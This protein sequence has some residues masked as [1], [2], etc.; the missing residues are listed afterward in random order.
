MRLSTYDFLSTDDTATGT[1]ERKVKS[2]A[3]M[4]TVVSSG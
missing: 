1:M 3:L 2:A 4:V